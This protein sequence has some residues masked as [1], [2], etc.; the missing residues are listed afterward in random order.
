MNLSRECEDVRQALPCRRRRE[1]NWS[2]DTAQH[3]VELLGINRC[4]SSCRDGGDKKRVRLPR[5]VRHERGEGRG[6]GCFILASGSPLRSASSPRPSPPLRAEEREPEAPVRTARTI[7]KTVSRGGG[8]L[9]RV[10]RGRGAHGSG[11]GEFWAKEWRQR[12]GDGETFCLH[13]FASIPLPNLLRGL[14]EE[15][16]R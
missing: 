12:N 9:Q 16:T 4:E 3:A 2:A 6:E 11:A 10:T 13:S 5:P 7:E 1:E 14:R 15:V 8:H